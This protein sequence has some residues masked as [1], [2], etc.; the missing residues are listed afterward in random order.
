M[1]KPLLI[2]KIL[3]R[4]LM[5]N[6]INWPIIIGAIPSIVLIIFLFILWSH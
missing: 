4:I 1:K 3:D 5:W 6:A 2:R